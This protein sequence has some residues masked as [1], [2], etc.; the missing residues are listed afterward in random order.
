LAALAGALIGALLLALFSRQS[1]RALAMNGYLALAV[2]LSIYIGAQLV[3]GSLADIG[4]EL[5]FATIMLVAA[6]LVMARWLPGIGA[7]IVAHGAYDAFLG[8]NTGVAAW[9]PP[10]CAGFDLLVGIGMIFIL[11]SKLANRHTD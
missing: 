5:L 6:R 10:M 8:A 4:L 9:Y 2:M 11:R 1:A 3:T 7:M